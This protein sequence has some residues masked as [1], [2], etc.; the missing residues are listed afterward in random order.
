MAAR[1]Q[2]ALA[3]PPRTSTPPLI[4]GPAPAKFHRAEHKSGVGSIPHAEFSRP[5]FGADLAATRPNSAEVR[6][7]S[8]KVRGV[9]ARFGA[10]ST[11][12]G[13]SSTNLEWIRQASGWLRPE[14]GRLPQANFEQNTGRN[15][16]DSECMHAAEFRQSAG[17]SPPA[18]HRL[19]SPPSPARRLTNAGPVRP[20]SGCCL[21]SLRRLLP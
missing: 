14:W 3:L 19:R 5:T 18:P 17:L 2:A 8:A 13:M 9:S 15:P 12:L 7:M 16:T 1:A 6:A 11:R 21:P 20:K 10:D 4:R